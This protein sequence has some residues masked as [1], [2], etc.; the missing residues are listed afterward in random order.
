MPIT[1]LIF[2]SYFVTCRATCSTRPH[3]WRRV[4]RTVLVDHAADRRAGVR[5]RVDLAVHANLERFLLGVVV[6][7]SPHGRR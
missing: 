6:L 3:Q 5:R 1:A 7:S 4:L 2:R